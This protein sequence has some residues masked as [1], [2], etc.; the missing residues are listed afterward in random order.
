MLLKRFTGLF[1]SLFWRN[2]REI[3]VSAFSYSSIVCILQESFHF[4]EVI[5]LLHIV[6]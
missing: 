6:C 5:I 4:F 2:Y 3:I 1:K